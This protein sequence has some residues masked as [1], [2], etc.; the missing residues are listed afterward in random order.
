MEVNTCL[1]NLSNYVDLLHYNPRKDYLKKETFE[2]AAQ[3][4]SRLSMQAFSR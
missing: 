3:E 4:H 2:S 1:G